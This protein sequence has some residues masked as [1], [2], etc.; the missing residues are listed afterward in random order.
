MVI[1]MSKKS[2][3]VLLLTAVS[4]SCAAQSRISLATDEPEALRVGITL[5]QEYLEKSTGERPAVAAGTGENA[6]VIRLELRPSMS[7]GPEAFVLEFPSEKEAVIAGG[8]PLAVRHGVCEFLERF[9]GV[10]WLYSG[11]EGEYVPKAAGIPKFPSESIRMS[12]AYRIRTF[13]LD[14][15][16]KQDYL[17]AAKN[18][19]IF[20]YDF[21]A[22]PG[23][24]WFHHNMN[25]LL[26]P[27][28]YVSTHPEFFPVIKG[29]RL[30][31]E[32]GGAVSWQYC[33]TAPG[34]AEELAAVTLRQ[35]REGRAAS[36]SFGVNDGNG[37]CE[38]ERCQATDGHRKN[39]LG[40]EDHSRSYLS[41]I[42]YAAEK[43]AAPG[44]TFGF[45]AYAHTLEVPD[46]MKIHP[47]LCPFITYETLFWADPGKAELARRI[48]RNW[49]EANG[50][51]AGWYDYLEHSWFAVPKI[52]L[53][54]IPAALRWGAANGVIHYYAEAL[55][56]DDW[57][58]GP[59]LWLILKLVWDP[60]Q[61]VDALLD[62]W[63][64]AAVGDDAA[65]CLRK[66]Y[67]A[68]SDF[69]ELEV[70]RTAFFREPRLY[71][72]RSSGYLDAMP[73]DWPDRMKPILDEMVERASSDRKARAEAIRKTFLD[74]EAAIRTYLKNSKLRGEAEKMD[75]HRAAFFDFDQPRL[76]G[77]WQRPISRGKFFHAPGEGIGGSGALAMDL[78]QSRGSMVFMSR[79]KAEPK[80]V[81]RITAQ[82]RTNGVDPTAIV[83]L[84]VDWSAPG[85][86]TLDSA[87]NAADTLP[88]DGSFAWRKLC[89]LVAAPDIPDAVMRIMLTGDKSSRGVICWDNVQVEQAEIKE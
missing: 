85:K 15:S 32:K 23:Y 31:P 8:T 6:L 12:P 33:F 28:K 29:K 88:E 9:Y 49:I 61:N 53:N 76:W 78:D 72:G 50:A 1:H 81:Y 30:I 11:E 44:R 36:V 51:N 24:T 19:G 59:M 10:R 56:S 63:C 69:W 13:A 25:R 57:H 84:E 70:P 7:G 14:H 45:L 74:R 42:N 41:C 37:F 26:V 18:K 87:F 22:F 46:G 21:F 68:C 83:R 65:P 39:S 67:Q 82:V 17:W 3:F 55:P 34:I 71:L 2:F 58:T 20:S 66:W 89:I 54:V 43:C 27:E 80:H 79:M 4:L 75:F 35:F 60:E 38:C 62:D 52:S 77:T 40:I 16:R 5:L 86:G 48:T 47:S 64:R 73:P